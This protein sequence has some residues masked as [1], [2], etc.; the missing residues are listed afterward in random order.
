MD[1]K[2]NLTTLIHRADVRLN[3]ALAKRL[4]E[5]GLTPEQYTLMSALWKED[6]VNQRMLGDRIGKDRPN[7]TRILE[8][9]ERKGFVRRDKDKRDRRVHHVFLTESGRA[10]SKPAG[11]VMEGFRTDCF[12]GLTGSDEAMLLT[13]IGRLMRNLD[14]IEQSSTDQM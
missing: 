14:R 4:A 9:L 6:G 13:L 8:K 3:T 12:R 10:L 1:L 5:E 7:T 11:H 2:Q